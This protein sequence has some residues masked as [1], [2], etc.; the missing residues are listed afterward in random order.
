MNDATTLDVFGA[1]VEPATL[2]MQRLLPGPVERVWSYLADSNLRRQWLCAGALGTK[3]GDTFEWVWRNDEL[4]SP[5]GERPEGFDEEKRMQGRITEIRAP[6]R[7]GYEW[8]GVGHVIFDLEPQ[9]KDVLLTV[10]HERIP[11][12]R[13]ALGVSTGWHAHLDLLATRLAGGK[14][15]PFWDAM[16]RLRK[17][18]ERRQQALG[19]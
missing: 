11:N 17:I 5:V 15:E 7:L 3:A 1:L 9:G 13:T 10:I 8:P 12:A 6:Y 16:V 18:Y 19:E 4:T 2:R 14:A